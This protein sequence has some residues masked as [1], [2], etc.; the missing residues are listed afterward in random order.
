M[1]KS[2]VIQ[3]HSPTIRL[4]IA[5]QAGPLEL[6]SRSAALPLP[7]GPDGDALLL[8]YGP[9]LNSLR[10]LLLRDC[11]DLLIQVVSRRS[12]SPVSASDLRGMD[13]ISE[14]HGAFYNVACVRVFLEDHDYAFALTSAVTDF[15]KAIMTREA[16]AL[17]E[18]QAILAE[19][20]LPRLRFEGEAQYVDKKNGPRMLKVLITDWLD[21]FHEFHLCRTQPDQPLATAVWHE[22]R[23][24]LV[25]S[26]S[27]T[28]EAYR[29]AARL[30]TLCY[31]TASGR[32]VYP[33]HH[34]AGD[35]V[36]RCDD[37]SLDVRLI[38]VRDYKRLIHEDGEDQNPLLGLLHFFLNL[39]LRMRLDRLDGTGD[40][41]WMGRPCLD[42]CAAGFL[43]ACRVKHAQSSRFPD[44]PEI[45]GVLQS[46]EAIEL[47]ELLQIAAADGLIEPDEAPFLGQHLAEHAGELSQL[48]ATVGA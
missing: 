45:L 11:F 19:D 8:H 29:K 2:S 20:L 36:I 38:S 26:A 41:A 44:A 43:D 6:D 46:F 5:S 9:Y 32:Q 40:L 42:A 17:Q 48:L 18:V 15:Q 23:G 30:L 14:K 34:A 4:M 47:Y 22:S 12:G 39:T 37:E 33:W 3:V 16:Q 13:I 31:D 21:D 10:D 7:Q 25:L 35:F 1:P 27:Q 24:R 28:A